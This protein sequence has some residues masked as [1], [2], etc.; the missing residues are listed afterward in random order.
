MPHADSPA[1]KR[2]FWALVERSGLGA[3]LTRLPPRPATEADLLRLHTPAYVEKVRA[4]GD[5][6]G[7]EAGIDT[8]LG[9]GSFE[10]VLLSVAGG[11]FAAVDAV[12]GAGRQRLRA[13]R[14]AGRHAEGDAGRGFCIFANVAVAMRARARGRP[15][16]VA[17]VDWDVHHGNGTQKAFYADPS[18]LDDLDSPG[19]A[20]P[21]RYRPDR[22][23]TAKGAG[24]G[25]KINVPLPPGSGTALTWRRS[26]GSFCPRSEHFAGR[27][28]VASGLDA[29]VLIR[30]PA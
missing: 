11:A 22:R 5:A 3:Q 1:T 29:G 9:R 20:L 14:P 2:R 25:Y 15:K 21:G 30:S 26:S 18:M 7:G 28:F 6:N 10:I 13:G 8:M 27:L 16:R 19:P 17:V 24:R 4:L 12:I 23:R